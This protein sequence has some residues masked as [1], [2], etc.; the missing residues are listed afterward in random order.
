MIL[1]LGTS[2]LISKFTVVKSFRVQ[3]H[4]LSITLKYKISL[5]KLDTDKHSSL[6]SCSI[7]DEE[8]KFVN[9]ADRFFTEWIIFYTTFFFV[10]LVS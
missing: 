1:H 3:A 6:F 5:K 9:T 7:G 2:I 4:S 10:L 8:K